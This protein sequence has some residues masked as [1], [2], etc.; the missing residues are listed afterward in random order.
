[1]RFR[2][3]LVQ[4]GAA[5]STLTAVA[6]D[7]CRCC[8]C[9]PWP[10]RSR[11]PVRV[12]AM[13]DTQPALMCGKDWNISWHSSV[14]ASHTELPVL[15]LPARYGSPAHVRAMQKKRSDLPN[16]KPCACRSASTASNFACTPVSCRVHTSAHVRRTTHLCMSVLLA[17]NAPWKAPWKPA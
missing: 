11:S 8:K 13:Q 14:C 5:S 9:L 4:H 16:A 17:F 15:A 2:C 10:A 6:N 12:R 7:T 1:M 3:K